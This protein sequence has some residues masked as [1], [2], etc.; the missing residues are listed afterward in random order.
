MA[1]INLKPLKQQT[2]KYKHESKEQAASFYNSMAWKRL[3]DTLLS[4]HPLCD[5]CL[6]HGYVVSAEH[7]HH[8]IPFMSGETE[9]ERWDLFLKESNIRM[10][11]ECCHHGYHNKMR[12]YNMKSCYELTDTEY[13]YAHGLNYLKK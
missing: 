6:Q 7:A 3:R 9:Q 13:N 2:I 1:R 10:L 12:E 5:E 11:C 8:L 4:T